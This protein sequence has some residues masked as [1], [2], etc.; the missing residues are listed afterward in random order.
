MRR[1]KEYLLKKY[2]KHKESLLTIMKARK[3]GPWM[4]QDEWIES[5]IID[6]MIHQYHLSKKYIDDRANCAWIY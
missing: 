4:P 3:N 6:A 5:N 2:K 1:N